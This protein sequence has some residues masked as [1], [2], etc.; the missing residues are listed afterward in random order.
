MYTPNVVMRSTNHDPQSHHRGDDVGGGAHP[1]VA[2]HRHDAGATPTAR[3]V[4]VEHRRYS[5]NRPLDLHG[6]GRIDVAGLE[7]YLLLNHHHLLDAQYVV[8]LENLPGGASDDYG[9]VCLV[10]PY[11][12]THI[13]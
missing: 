7:S 9:F 10:A 11:T 13:E 8:L 2:I 4:P 1:T 12:D 5:G 6:D 3:C